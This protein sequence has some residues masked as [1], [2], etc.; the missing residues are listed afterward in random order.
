LPLLCFGLRLGGYY[1]EPLPHQAQ[2]EETEVPHEDVAIPV[3]P[4]K[5][6]P[7]EIERQWYEQLYL[8]RGAHMR[9]LTWRAIITGTL[10]GSF[11]SLANLYVGLKAGWGL[12][13]PISACILSYAIWTVFFRI[14]LTKTPMTILENNCMQSAATSSA[15][16][17][18][19]TLISAFSA[20]IMI[21]GHSLSIPLLM[22]WVFFLAL[23]GVTMAIPMKRQ[24]VNIDQL[25]FPT[26]TAIAE[27]LRA[28]HSHGTRGIRAAK[29]LGISSVIGAVSAFWGDGLR[30]LSEKVTRL[31]WVA[32]ISL[33]TFFGAF[34][35]NVVGTTW[36]TRTVMF[37]WDIVMMAFGSIT[38]LRV[39]SSMLFGATL[40]WGVFVPILQ[41]HGVITGTQYRDIVQ[42]TLWGGVSCMVFSGL[43]SFVLQWRTTV[44]AF[45]SLR[46]IF[47]RGD[48]K[49]DDVDKVETPFS[50]FL[51]GQ[52]IGLV[53]LI[54][55]GQITFGMPWWQTTLAVVLSFFLAL[56]ACRITGET[57][58]TPVGPMGK[59]TQML[60]GAISPGKMD[61]NLFS[62][63]ITASAANSSADLLTD[64]KSG[65]LLGANPR[66]QFIAQFSGIFIGTVVTVFGFSLLV[67]NDATILGSAQLPAPAA[68]TWKA[69]AE[70][71][72][73]GL[74]EL[75]PIKVWSIV[76]GGLVGIILPLLSKL[77]PKHEKWI[78]SP[79]GLGLA[80]TF[81]WYTSLQFFIGALAGYFFTR[82]SPAKSEEYLFTIASG[83]IVGG[84]LMGIG[85]IF[86]EY[87][88][89]MWHALF[90]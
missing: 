18:G 90:H 57:D 85:L 26:G 66:K 60:F 76:I 21:Y 7:E 84:S 33:D 56:V 15:S 89:K 32:D 80:W 82:K 50:W 71:M 78:P 13:A 3:E 54:Y 5:G 81:Q 9:Q 51:I 24:M 27:T 70:A 68:Q 83:I 49:E 37:N 69:V 58:T 22:G 8:K 43:F 87:G 34:N 79:S 44:R 65:Y 88:P 10:L 4:F 46:R 41:S 19:A 38:G 86:W 20:Y 75:A 53:G 61:I 42:W 47:A 17:T 40:C 2:F 74:S 31:A 35:K 25:R 55:L 64:L 77:F 6:S 36:M 73:K 62:A 12:G 45:S 30:I 67:G 11:L 29:V 39:C 59:V 63:N 1:M 48:V 72:S 52:L 28:L 16:S 23:M 14:G